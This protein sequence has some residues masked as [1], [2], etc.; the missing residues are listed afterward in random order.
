MNQLSCKSHP[1]L[2]PRSVSNTLHCHFPCPEWHHQ[3]NVS[4]GSHWTNPGLSLAVLRMCHFSLSRLAF[5]LL[6]ERYPIHHLGFFPYSHF[7]WKIEGF[8]WNDIQW[9]QSWLL[10]PLSENNRSESSHSFLYTW[11]YFKSQRC[12]YGW[13]LLHRAGNAEAWQ[14]EGSTGALGRA[15]VLLI[16]RSHQPNRGQP[17]LWALL[18]PEV[19]LLGF[20][21]RLQHTD[22]LGQGMRET[23]DQS[24][25]TYP[26]SGR[27]TRSGFLPTPLTAALHLPYTWQVEQQN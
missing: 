9:V 20:P 17:R 3:D 10:L 13:L 8:P 4:F 7:S 25:W 26:E 19:P 21:L 5:I 12:S 6:N 22:L 18:G 15:E 11:Q 27:K 23:R 1:S 14:A 24:T 16:S 2:V